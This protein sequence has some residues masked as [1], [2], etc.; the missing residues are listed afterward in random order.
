MIS[1]F[2]YVLNA[3]NRRIETAKSE[4]DKFNVQLQKSPVSALSWGGKAFKAA[5]DIEVAQQLQEE[6]GMLM[7]DTKRTEEQA[8]DLAH[9]SLRR[10]VLR[11]ARCNFSSSS[12]SSVLMENALRIA[13]AEALDIFDL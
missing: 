13:R 5:A 9:S 2:E 6:L 7:E 11:E 4:L 3:L 12:G 10:R 1:K 8:L